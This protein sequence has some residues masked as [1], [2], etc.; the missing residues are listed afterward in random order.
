MSSKVQL[1]EKVKSMSDLELASEEMRLNSKVS[2]IIIRNEWR[3]RDKIE[4]HKLDKE[5]IKLQ[6]ESTRRISLTAAFI[7][8]VAAIIGAATGAF[9][10]AKIQHTIQAEE[11]KKIIRSEIQSIQTSTSQK[12]SALQVHNSTISTVESDTKGTEVSA[13]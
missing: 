6:G 4:Q 7:G 1:N 5:L 9:V 10:Q 11:I 8:V 3:R 13:Q 2:E 12:E